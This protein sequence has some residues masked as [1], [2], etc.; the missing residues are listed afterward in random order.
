M[1]IKKIYLE[2]FLSYPN[3]LLDLSEGVNIIT[4]ANASGKTNLVDSIYYASIGKSAKG[5][6]DKELIN[7]DSKESSRIKILV[8]KKYGDHTIE[9]MI[10]KLGK[11]RVLIDKLP[12]QRMGE[13]VGGI[14]VVYFSPD[15]MKLIK[16]SPVDRRRF[17][18]ISLCQ[19][20]KIYLYTLIRYN[21]L[22]AQRNKVLKNHKE[23]PSLKEMS[24]IIVSKMVEAEEYIITK[25][26]EFLDKLTPVANECHKKLTSN[27]EDLAIVYETEQIDF[28]DIKGSL[29][30]LYQKSWEKDS[31]L[32]YT[33]VGIH[34]DD[35]KISAGGIDIR[36]YGSQGQQRTAVLSLKLA[37]VL[38]FTSISGEKPILL[39]D[40]VLSELDIDRQ[41]N[42]FDSLDVQTV[43]TCTEFDESI[44]D[45]YSLYKVKDNK[46][47]LVRKD[48]DK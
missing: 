13:L 4:G 23:S 26:V 48:N 28:S 38:S 34:R 19:L 41:R 10:D 37:E 40:D 12:I 45:K 35:L 44:T 17:M 7:W 16:E 32:E 27:K 21:K 29:L 46:I 14:N 43:V 15:E 25:R 5:L 42:L 22:L 3:L 33:T 8:E 6:K 9:I 24:D 31:Y 1:R 2:N 36:K 20:D 30:S 18:D 47:S 39:M 11:K